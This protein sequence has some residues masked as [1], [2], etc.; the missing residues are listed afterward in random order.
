MDGETHQPHK[1]FV[2]TNGGNGVSHAQNELP[3]WRLSQWRPVHSVVRA[4][5]SMEWAEG[6]GGSHYEVA[7]GRAHSTLMR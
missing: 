6:P 2:D 4:G 7:G 3:W 1:H 5:L